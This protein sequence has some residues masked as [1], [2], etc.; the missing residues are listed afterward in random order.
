MGSK[1]GRIPSA[2]P[3]QE[4]LA[5]SPVRLRLFAFV[6][7][8]IF[9][10][11]LSR[12]WFLQILMGEEL[13]AKAETSGRRE[14]RT[15]APRGVIE[16]RN[17]TVLVTN[18]AQ[19]TV[20]V[21]EQVLPKKKPEREAVFNLL[22]E[23]L[24]KT[25]TELD[26]ILK[27]NRSG[28]EP[29]AVAEGI[30]QHT[31]A[32]IAER[33]HLM[34]GVN[35][36]VEPLRKY[37]QGKTAA[38]LIGY[39]GSI[40]K[41]LEDAEVVKRGYRPG[42]FIGKNGVEREYDALLNGVAGSI[43]Y[44]TDARG[45][46]LRELERNDPTAGATLRLALDLPAQK[47]A[48]AA[49]NNRKG[50]V[51]A[52]DPRD[53][54]VLAMASF[55]TFDPNLLAQR[56]SQSV[57]DQ[58]VAPGLFNRALKAAQPPG[59]TFKIVTAAAV[60]GEDKFSRNT[61]FYCGGGMNVGRRFFRCHSSH[62]TVNLIPAMAQSC[63]V[64]FY[65]A[66]L[67]VGPS[68]LAEWGERFGLGQDP[69]IDL[70]FVNDGYMPSP[71][72][73]AD[74]ARKFGNPDTNWYPGFTANTSIGQGD[75]QATPLQMAMVVSAIANGGTIYS[76]RV[77]LEAKNGAGEV[78]YRM[79]P[80]PL[81]QLGISKEKLQL[82]AA[83]L[84]AVVTGGT[85]QAAALPGIAVA[86]KSGSAELKG[87][88]QGGKSATHAWFVCYAPVEKPTIAICVYLESEGQNYHGGSDAAPIA[89]KVMAAYFRVPDTGVDSV[90]TTA[91]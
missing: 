52:L 9:A 38:H 58:Q 16:D 2:E 23:V 59:S 50:A 53:G 8:C 62:G 41:E 20:F 35:A 12:L 28:S 24:G 70:P 31:L 49:L 90:G 86:G 37:P 54:R 6:I 73:H 60:F 66:G 39:V 55:P 27:R 63:D 29:I 88:N 3:P 84:R 89:R 87:G 34:P 67:R 65:Q 26:A 81:N 91:D 47:A 10:V 51:V 75:V 68:K 77:L 43:G 14:V 44:E 56:I 33:Q 74:R 1:R 82:I 40:G 18:S 19:F 25:R 72:S 71:E 80:K 46:R 48:E 15:V 21:D 13:R 32:R 69:E 85:S 57:Y 30:D 4:E 83:S 5:L 78:V 11:L 42:D 61:S 7:V 64:Y 45:R 79:Q 17:G 76:P 36:D 22:A